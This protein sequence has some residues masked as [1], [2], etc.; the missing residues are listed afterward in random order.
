V[1]YA[2]SSDLDEKISA[3]TSLGP[4]NDTTI[5]NMPRCWEFYMV[6]NG[7]LYQQL[8]LFLI[9]KTRFILGV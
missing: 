4:F 8:N 9:I 6:R 2:C 3:M 5:A 7:Y 1:L